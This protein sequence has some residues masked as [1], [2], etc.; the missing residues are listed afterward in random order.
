MGHPIHHRDILK[1]GYYFWKNWKGIFHRCWICCCCQWLPPTKLASMYPFYSHLFSSEPSHKWRGI[2]GLECDSAGR[3]LAYV[4]CIR[5]L[6]SSPAPHKTQYH[7][8]CL[9][10]SIQK[11]K[12]G[13]L[14]VQGH[15]RLNSKYEA[16]LTYMWICLR[17]RNRDRK[18]G[19]RKKRR[20]K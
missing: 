13:G 20:R 4:L 8:A 17:Q 19:E 7:G 1:S 9:I 6:V 15:P 2:W 5:P 11:V 18:E 10:P 16:S 3:M 12:A 14:Q